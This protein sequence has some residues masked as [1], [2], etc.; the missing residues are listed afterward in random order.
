MCGGHGYPDPSGS[1]IASLKKGQEIQVKKGFGFP[2]KETD[3]TCIIARVSGFSALCAD[4]T[5]LGC[6]DGAG[7]VTTETIHAEFELSPAAQQKIA[8]VK[9]RG[10]T[11]ED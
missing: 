10:F 3:T 11:F 7:V 5:L 8:E 6:Q 9:A 4:G 1:I 2:A